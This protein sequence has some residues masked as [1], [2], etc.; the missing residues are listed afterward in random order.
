MILFS[1]WH[2][3][4]PEAAMISTDTGISIRKSDVQK[5]SPRSSLKRPSD[6]KMIS[7]SDEHPVNPKSE[8][9]STDAE[10]SIG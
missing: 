3:K 6:A 7:D 8:M 9:I 5:Q 4:K 10:I 1:E 2:A